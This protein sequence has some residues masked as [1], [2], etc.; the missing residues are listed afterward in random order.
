MIS[1]DDLVAA[2]R[3]KRLQIDCRAITLVQ[4]IARKP[5]TYTG[6]GYI[7]QNDDDTFSLKLYGTETLNTDMF[8][9]FQREAG[10]MPGELY[11]ESAFF[12]MTAISVDNDKWTS[13]RI[14]PHGNWDAR[15]PNPVVHANL[16]RLVK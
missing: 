16:S 14:L 13:D 6:K 5:V 15:D 9:S 12:T 10:G 3:Q 8:A 11:A 2:F 7:R 1:F 4:N